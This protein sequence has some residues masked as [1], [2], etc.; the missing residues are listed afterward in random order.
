I[1]SNDGGVTVS[2]DG[3]KTW[4]REDNQPTAQFYHVITDNRTPYFVYGAQQDNSTIGI[5]SRS[6]EGS[7]GRAD[8]YDVGGGESGYIAPYPPDPNIVYAGGYQG[9]I[10]RFDKRTG[11]RKDVRVMPDLSDGGGAANL[12]HR[13]QW[14][15]PIF[16]SPHDPN[17]LYQAGE[18]LFKTTDGGIHWV[19]ISPDLTRNDASPHDAG[20]AYL[21]IDRH[22]NDDLRPYIY[23]TND[24]GKSWT[25]IVS[26]IPENTFVRAVREDPKKRGLLYAGTE[27]GMFVSFNDGANWR[28]L[29][30][31]LPTTPVHDLVVKNDDLV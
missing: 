11:E 9:Q 10:T 23:K 14:T 20:T 7:I 25:K 5:A 24:Y 16:F 12:D 8:W 30:L 6:D 3:G 27:T 22:Q 28:A 19:A 13:F 17:T 1:V 29:K 4:T 31:N 2:L 15:A 21:A 26:G 18:R